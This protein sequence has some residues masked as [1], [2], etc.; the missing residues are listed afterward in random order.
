[1]K[2]RTVQSLVG[3]A[4]SA[5]STAKPDQIFGLNQ[6]FLA[7]MHPSKISLVIG[8]YRDDEGK[9]YVF[10]VVRW[11]E[12]AML[13]DRLHKEYLQMEGDPVYTDCAKRLVFSDECNILDRIMT[14]QTLSGTGALRLGGTFLSYAL[15]KKT[16]VYLSDPTWPNHMTVL[17]HAGLT[18]QGFYPYYDPVTKSL[19][20]K[21]MMDTLSKAETGSIVLLHGCAHNP[22][23]IDPTREQWRDIA[24]LCKLKSL[25]PFID[26]AYQGFATGDL[27]KDAYAVRLFAEQGLQLL[28]AQSFAKNAGLYGERVGALHI[29][30][31]NKETAMK[32]LT[33]IQI[34]IRG[35][36][37]N[38]PCH[39]A[40]I[41]ARIL[42]G[43][44]YLAEW[45]VELKAISERIQQT[46]KLL[47][48][49]LMKLNTPG[50][51]DHILNQIGMF[52]YTGLTPEQCQ[53]M[54]SKHHVYL[55][56]SGRISMSGINTRN[57]EY[58]A[59]AI[60]DAVTSMP[61]IQSPSK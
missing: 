56:K 17:K 29:V 11:V 59:K 61:K 55:L 13:R 16:K 26:L 24:A 54:I 25:I 57:V 12:E 33:N 31:P 58:L 45:K 60:H 27:D 8:S 5:V 23:G 42:S 2:L 14:V 7:D 41:M 9:P 43:P 40:R 3:N 19:N 15:P 49:E 47:H 22:T 38:P 44:D 34:D 46:R 37:S 4:W 35:M 30:C 1:M 18:N 48:G 20:Y 6:Q 36:Y 39:G 50:K 51:W 32:V 52:S 28:V 53:Y 21:G 10:P